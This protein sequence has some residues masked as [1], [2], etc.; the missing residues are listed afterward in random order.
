MSQDTTTKS[1]RSMAYI[2][3]AEYRTGINHQWNDPVMNRILSFDYMGSTEFE[4]GALPRTHKFLRSRKDLMIKAVKVK[5]TKGEMVSIWAISTP[6]GIQ[7]FEDKIPSHALGKASTKEWTNLY[8]GFNHK[9]SSIRTD[10]WVD[11]SPFLDTEDCGD[12]HP[13]YF[14]FKKIPAIRIFL[15]LYRTHFVKEQD[16]AFELNMFDKVYCHLTQHAG[17][18]AGL[19]QDDSLTF[20]VFHTKD[21]MSK[22]DL[23]PIQHFPIEVFQNAGIDYKPN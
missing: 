19:N 2:Q 12:D 7:R 14:T 15:E 18:V 1:Y 22:Y 17:K 9:D 4:L 21:R 3:R 11:I 10:V 23:W 8:E 5:N 6:E 13:V 16:E 20:K